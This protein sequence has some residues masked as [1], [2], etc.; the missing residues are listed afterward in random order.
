MK[1]IV[2]SLLLF[3]SLNSIS[4]TTNI[5]QFTVD[6]NTIVSIHDNFDN[7]AGAT[8]VNDGEVMFFK[9]CNND[10][11]FS[12]TNTNQGLIDFLGNSVHQ[13]TGTIP[14][15]FYDMVVNNSSG[16]PNAIELSGQIEITNS[17]NFLTGI[18]K[19]DGL[20]GEIT[21][22][23]NAISITPSD[24]SHIDGNVVKVGSINFD[25]PVGDSGYYR[26][27]LISSSSLPS[28]QFSAHYFYS[29]PNVIG[30]LSNHDPSITLIDNQEYWRIERPVGNNQVLL[31]LSYDF[32]KRRQLY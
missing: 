5:G 19:N 21:Y 6:P 28:D 18:I 1:N 12:F 31:S 23:Q 2:S 9:S 3:G 11:T 15:E 13:L 16:L 26:H 17:I 22:K 14:F 25:Y 24:I 29:N 27:A 32:N 7:K 30:P 10:A 4:Q 8:F 20:G